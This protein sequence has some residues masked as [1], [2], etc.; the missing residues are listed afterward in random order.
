MP[1]FSIII[2]ACLLASG[3][4]HAANYPVPSTPSN[5]IPTFLIDPATGQPTTSTGGSVGNVTIKPAPLSGQG[6][7]TTT[8]NTST[9]VNGALTT[10][11]NS[12]AFPTGTLPNGIITIEPEGTASTGAYVC[13]LGG[14]CSAAVGEYLAPGQSVT[15]ALPTQSMATQPP[16]LFSTAAIAVVVKW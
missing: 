3:V 13:W 9:A 2:A 8:A 15:V 4:A 14:T 11:A 1:R 7:A 12:A 6:A 5:A 10:T 16:T